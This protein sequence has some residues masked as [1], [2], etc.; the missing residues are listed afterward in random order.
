[1]LTVE[2]F[3]KGTLET[4]GPEC[5]PPAFTVSDYCIKYYTDFDLFLACESIGRKEEKKG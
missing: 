4:E 2:E 5:D 1:M 3:E